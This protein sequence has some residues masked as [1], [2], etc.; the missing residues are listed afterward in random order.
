M[1]QS[2]YTIFIQMPCLLLAVLVQVV[3]CRSILR[4]RRQPNHIEVEFVMMVSLVIHFFPTI[5]LPSKDYKPIKNLQDLSVIS[6]CMKMHYTKS[7]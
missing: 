1:Y 7:Y 4:L 2:V 3:T 5:S 6:T